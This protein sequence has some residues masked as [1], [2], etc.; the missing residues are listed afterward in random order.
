MKDISAVFS[1]ISNI[2]DFMSFEFIENFFLYTQHDKGNTK[3]E[4]YTTF[5]EYQSM[6][7]TLTTAA[8]DSAAYYKG[9]KEK[10]QG[11]GTGVGNEVNKFQ[12]YVD[13]FISSVNVF[14][15]CDVDYYLR[16]FSKILTVSGAVNFGVNVLFRVF[17]TDDMDN[18]Y[19]MSLA[20]DSK[21]QKEAGESFGT[22]VSLLLMFENPE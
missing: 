1:L 12:G 8:N 5:K 7:N 3:S 18:Y 16:S 17:S 11:K 21:N 13:V 22:F 20:V 14:N 15:Y 6:Y 19:K 9:L 2:D 10:G 4:C